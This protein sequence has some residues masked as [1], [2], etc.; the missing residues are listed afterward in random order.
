MCIFIIHK[1]IHTIHIDGYMHKYMDTHVEN[2]MYK[3]T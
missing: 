2:I 3:Y 1:K